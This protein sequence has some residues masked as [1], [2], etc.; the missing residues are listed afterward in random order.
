MAEYT[1]EQIDEMIANAKKGLLPEE[2]I[3]KRVTA[4]VDR[5]VESGIQKGLETHK[6]KWEEEFKTKAQMT[7]EEIAQKELQDK[8][9]QMTV[10]EK[11]IQ[12]KAN[13]IDAKDMLSSA[14]I[15]KSH[16]EKFINVLVSDNEETTKANVQ[17]FIN[18]FNET[19]NEIETEVKKTY[20][21]V[22]APTGGSG[23]KE[24]TKE[25][26]RKMGYAEK[27]KLKNEKPE[28]YKELM[29]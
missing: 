6:Q 10:K 17:N 18:M 28:L 29:K 5:R 7:A 8:L 23:G 12:K 9:N 27:L 26:F 4:E 25:D 3:T 1:Q 22:P 24:I 15:P 16:Y 2:E 11:E 21:N 20:T 13:L 19:K 14:S